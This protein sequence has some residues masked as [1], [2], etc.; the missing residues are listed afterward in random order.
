MTRSRR[1]KWANRISDSFT[2]A[3]FLALKEEIT[4]AGGNVQPIKVR[5]LVGVA[6]RYEI[7]FGHRRHR[8]CLEAG[9]PVLCLIEAV[10]DQELFKEMDREKQG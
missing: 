7:V 6:D 9:L 1:Q 4:Q 3:D 8:A 2:S 5:P 10:S